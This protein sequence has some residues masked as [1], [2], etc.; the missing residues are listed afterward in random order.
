MKGSCGGKPASRPDLHCLGRICRLPAPDRLPRQGLEQATHRAVQLR[1]GISRLRSLSPFRPP[2]SSRPPHHRLSTA[3][4]AGCHGRR[5]PISWPNRWLQSAGPPP[6]TADPQHGSSAR[7]A[8]RPS[9]SYG[10]TSPLPSS[11]SR[12]YP[13]ELM[14]IHCKL[15]QAT[16]WCTDQRCRRNGP[17]YVLWSGDADIARASQRQHAVEDSMPYGAVCYVAINARWYGHRRQ[18]ENR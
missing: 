1:R 11:C 6:A 5:V 4:A 12:I 7:H 8:S 16:A 13:L 9:R 18:T 15:L 3:D 14:N 2:R 10:P 17:Y